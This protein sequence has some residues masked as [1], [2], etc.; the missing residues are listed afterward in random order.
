MRVGTESS[1]PSLTW[2]QAVL[3]A[4]AGDHRLLALLFRRLDAMGEWRA[5]AR[6]GEMY[7][8]GGI[9]L[10]RDLD[11]AA[12]WYR[13]AIFESDDPIAHLGMGRIYFAGTVAVATAEDM[14]KA[15]HHLDIAFRR[16]LGVAGMHLGIASLFGLAGPPDLKAAKTYFEAAAA[17]HYPLAYRYLA[18]IAAQSGRY[19]QAL[20][21]RLREGFEWIKLKLEDP[22]HPNLW[23]LGK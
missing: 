22:Q 5:T 15:K 4:E 7:E 17:E 19:G 6:L 12:F 11:E 8:L 3:A 2:D 21:L 13:K 9:G 23:M 16:G 1:E 20:R 18:Y 14:G 10:D